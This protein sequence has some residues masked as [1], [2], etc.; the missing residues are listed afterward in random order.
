MLNRKRGGGTLLDLRY[1]YTLQES[2]KN[3]LLFIKMK[4]WS[5]IAKTMRNEI[6]FFIPN[7]GGP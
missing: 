4:T 7:D 6:S 1:A 2:S 5:Q 3:G